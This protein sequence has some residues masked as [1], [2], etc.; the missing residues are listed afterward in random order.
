ML[1]AETRELYFPKHVGQ[2]FRSTRGVAG[3]RSTRA[4]SPAP[5]SGPLCRFIIVVHVFLDR[6]DCGVL[7]SKKFLDR[8]DCGVSE[9]FEIS[10]WLRNVPSLSRGNLEWRQAE[11][12][13]E[14]LK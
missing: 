10:E 13:W 3:F 9:N 4:F 7:E 2:H 14:M 12:L 5:L 1:A 6:R 8:R 11:T